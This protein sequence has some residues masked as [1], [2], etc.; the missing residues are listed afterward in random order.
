MPSVMTMA[1]STS[2][3]RA[4]MRA[5]SEMRSRISPVCSMMIIVPHMVMNR[6][7]PMMSPLRTPIARSKTTK[8]ITTAIPSS[9]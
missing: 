7:A 3:T 6:I 9:E 4:M 8:T 2:I 5:P 1:L